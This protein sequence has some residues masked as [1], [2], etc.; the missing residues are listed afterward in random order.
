M[1]EPSTFW[2]KD[3]FCFDSVLRL[4]TSIEPKIRTLNKMDVNN[5]AIISRGSAFS[6]GNS[7]QPLH[8]ITPLKA[9]VVIIPAKKT[10][11]ILFSR[12]GVDI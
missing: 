7:I 10:I 3:I 1:V 9:W 8:L 11:V 12:I 5:T 4:N 2:K 6:T